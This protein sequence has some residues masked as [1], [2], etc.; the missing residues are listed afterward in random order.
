MTDDTPQDLL[1]SH[2][3]TTYLHL[4]HST[5]TGS[6]DSQL[7]VSLDFPT[8]IPLGSSARSFSDV[9]VSPLSAPSRSSSTSSVPFAEGEVDVVTEEG[10][11]HATVKL[12]AR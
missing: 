9:L 10:L 1:S 6:M 11:R 8:R 3:H 2:D 4:L 12:N 7:N 5:P